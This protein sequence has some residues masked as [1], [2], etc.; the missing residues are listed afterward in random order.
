VAGRQ[1]LL[2][3]LERARD[4]GLLGPGPVAA[5]LDHAARWA[6][7]LGPEAGSFLDLGAGAGVPGLALLALWPDA[8]ATFLDARRR[9]AEFL[10]TAAAELGWRDRVAVAE[11][12]A[13]ELGRDPE[14]RERFPL[15]VARGFGSPPETA[16][17]G[18]AFVRPGGRLSVSEPPAGDPARWPADGLAEVGLRHV[19]PEASDAGPS[20][21][22]LEK[23]DP[24]GGRFPRRVGIPRRRPL[25]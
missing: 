14:L 20:F 8:T 15:V 25:W 5:H 21:V 13:E 6:T 2:D 18:S 4:I 17:C 10:V 12:R 23:T 1:E 7:A 16:E 9:S 11:G 19:T 22:I 3:V 24:L